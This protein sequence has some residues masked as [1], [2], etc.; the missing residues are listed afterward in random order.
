MLQK[1]IMLIIY[2]FFFLICPH[3]CSV[4]VAGLCSKCL[5]FM[6]TLSSL[7]CVVMSRIT[8][9]TRRHIIPSC[10]GITLIVEQCMLN[11]EQCMLV[12][13]ANMLL[14]GEV[15]SRNAFFFNYAFLMLQKADYA[16]RNASIMG[17]SLPSSSR[18]ELCLPTLLVGALSN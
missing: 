12:A 9:S 17:L 18:I 6:S 2:A 16:K 1:S 15:C 4:L 13:Q 10:T 11:M 8:D 14:F 5:S 7:M 3:L